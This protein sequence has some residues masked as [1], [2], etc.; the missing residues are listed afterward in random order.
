MGERKAWKW[1][2]CIEYSHKIKID[3]EQGISASYTLVI[4]VKQGIARDPVPSQ[5]YSNF[6]IHSYSS[7]AKSYQPLMC[8]ESK[9]MM[10][11]GRH[12]TSVLK[13]GR[14]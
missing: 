10:R 3:Q 12:L 4:E 11:R 6:Y 5:T 13:Q 7:T 1:I 9:S 14:G 8:E 2:L